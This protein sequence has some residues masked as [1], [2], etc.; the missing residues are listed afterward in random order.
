MPPSLFVMFVFPRRSS[1][2][3]VVP[4]FIMLVGGGCVSS[5]AVFV[6]YNFAGFV[7]TVTASCIVCL[8]FSGIVDLDE[9]IILP[10]ASVINMI[11]T[12]STSISRRT[13]FPVSFFQLDITFPDFSVVRSRSSL[14]SSRPTLSLFLSL[15]SSLVRVCVSLSRFLFRPFLSF[16]RTRSSFLISQNRR[17][18][19]LPSACRGRRTTP[20][21]LG[22][23]QEFSVF[24]ENIDRRLRHVDR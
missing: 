5:V 13:I 23:E 21:R 10:E 12:K 16:A 24:T 15:S 19:T 8:L 1:I 11:E 18:K 3:G 2:L 17:K 7:V 22:L 9:T 14:F 20:F 4:G 6:G